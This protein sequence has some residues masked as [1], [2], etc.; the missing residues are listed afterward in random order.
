MWILGKV[1]QEIAIKNSLSFIAERSGERLDKYVT[2]HCSDL[3]RSKVQK[4]IEEGNITVN[5]AAAKSSLKLEPGDQVDVTVPPPLPSTLIP[6]AIPLKILYEDDDLMVVDKPAGLTVHPAPGH[7]DGTLANA[8]LAHVPSLAGGESM[9]PGIVH[10]LDKDTSGLIIVAKNDAAHMKLA[11]QF[12]NRSVTKI[13]LALV[14]GRISPRQGVIEGSIGRDPRDRKRMAVVTQGREARTEYKVIEYLGNTT[15]LE[16]K[17]RTGRTHQIRVHL[18]A[19]G[20]PIVGDTTYGAKSKFLGRQFLHAS[21]LT[22][23]LPSSGELRQF[24][25][26]LPEDLTRALADIAESAGK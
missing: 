6:Q 16:I 18:A 25:S 1:V 14:Q 3:S 12:K 10:R 17:P 2:E 9:R 11:D 4:L 19:I 26:E 15:L 24:R 21:Q 13:Y 22:F 7:F 5:G 23:K 8:V 20:F